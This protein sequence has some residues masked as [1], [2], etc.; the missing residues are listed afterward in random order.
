M[1]FAMIEVFK[2]AGVLIYPLGICSAAAV[3]IIFE[4][5]YALRKAAVMP[6]DLAD[7]VVEGRPQAHGPRP[8]RRIRRAAPA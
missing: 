8:D 3:F 6:Q 2:G 1:Y 5:A 4:R 7:A